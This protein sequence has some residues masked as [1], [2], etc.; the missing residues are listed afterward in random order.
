M[1]MALYID[2]AFLNDI[3]NVARTVPLAGVTTNPSILLA[4][5]ERGQ[6]LKPRQLLDELLRVQDGSVFIQPGATDEE[7][8][9]AEASEYIQAA[10]GRVIPKI[11][12]TAVG[13]RVARRLQ[14][15]QHRIAFTAVTNVTQTYIAAMVQADFIIPYYNRLARAGV[16]ANERISEM[17]D[18]LQN[19]GQPTRILVASIK[20]QQEAAQALLAGADDLTTGPQ[21]LLDMVNDPLS[22]QA[23]EKFSQDWQKMNKL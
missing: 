13:V 11:P 7:G 5:R 21:V 4:A 22:E 19:C 17:A 8:M 18:I 12:L 20:T 3:T 15:Q 16:D 6:N 2:C 1:D 10:P 9:Y 14:P 23:V